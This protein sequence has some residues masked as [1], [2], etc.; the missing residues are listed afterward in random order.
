MS[1][2]SVIECIYDCDIK[3]LNGAVGRVVRRELC[4]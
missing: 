2:I 3:L 4:F 1:A